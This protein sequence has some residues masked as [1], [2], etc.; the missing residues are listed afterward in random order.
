M[1]QKWLDYLTWETP[2]WKTAI[3]R[4]RLSTPVRLAVEQGLINATDRVLDF[5]CGRGDDVMRLMALGVDAR[6]FDPYYLNNKFDSAA[7]V[8]CGFVINVIEEEDER[9]EVLRFVWELAI[10]SLIVSVR[11]DNKES[12]ITSI[13]TYQKYYTQTEFLA[14]VKKVL[15]D[16]ELSSPKSGVA[17]LQK[18]S[19]VTVANQHPTKR[20][21]V[22]NAI[23]ALQN[24]ISDKPN[25]DTISRFPGAGVLKEAGV[26]SDS[27]KPKW[28]VEAREEIQGLLTPEQFAGLRNVG[29]LNQ[30]F[31]S[32]EVAQEIW[33]FAFEYFG[34]RSI[35]VLDPGCGVAGFYHACP[36]KHL[37]EYVGIEID[38]VT[39]GMAQAS[40]GVMARIYN[41]DFLTWEFPRQ[42][43]L[44]IGNIPFT[45]GVKR[46]VLDDRRVN[47]GIH[48]QFI[49]TAIGHLTSGGLLCVLTTVNT[50]DSV[51]EDYVVFREW[52]RDRVEFLGAIRLP[53]DA[54][55][56]I[57]GTEVTTDLLILRKK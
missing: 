23:A 48:A 51:G 18:K 5:G 36:H 41:R 6:G 4:D 27:I 15:P 40:V 10:A 56:H 33:E 45:N 54:N 42:F 39:A 46:W 26:F 57:G 32:P 14:W 21:L 16:A 47:L 38:S 7:I 9:V 24:F 8:N 34:H 17:F 1:N 11:T 20:Q 53:C 28:A 43:D 22:E 31:T 52:C 44:V 25:P 30:H 29:L 19:K 37:V 3:K 55:T 35:K 49:A 12:G 13:G 2:R 50:L